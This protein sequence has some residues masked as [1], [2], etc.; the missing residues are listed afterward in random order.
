MGECIRLE[1]DVDGE[2]FASA[3]HASESVELIVLVIGALVF[4]TLEKNDRLMN[5]LALK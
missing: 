3:G 5:L 1:Y 2:N 4:K